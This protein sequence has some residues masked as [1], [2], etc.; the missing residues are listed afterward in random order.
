MV[1]QKGNDSVINISDAMIADQQKL[2]VDFKYFR[3]VE[4]DFMLPAN[5][6][7]KKLEVRLMQGT[8]VVA[9]QQVTM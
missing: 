3:R 8:T 7:L 1:Q 6:V 2:L 4:G 5:A 9:S